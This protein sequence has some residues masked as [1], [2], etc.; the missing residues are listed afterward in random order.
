MEV[1]A[2]TSATK[3]AIHIEINVELNS[4]DSTISADKWMYN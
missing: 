4:D 3:E 1:S 2:A